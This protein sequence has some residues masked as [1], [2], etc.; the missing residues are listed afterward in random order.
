MRTPLTIT[1]AV[2]YLQRGGRITKHYCNPTEEPKI[3]VT[4]PTQR[5]L[6]DHSFEINQA[7][8]QAIANM[9]GV[10]TR[11]TTSWRTQLVWVGG[12]Q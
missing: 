12:N 10:D 4:P 7:T 3:V 2:L 9:E 5:H 1:T 6:A 8:F 11:W